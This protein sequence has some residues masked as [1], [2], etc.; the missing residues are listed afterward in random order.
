MR[1]SSPETAIKVPM[2]LATSATNSP[3]SSSV[4]TPRVMST[5]YGAQASPMRRTCGRGAR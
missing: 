5:G 4:W 1:V 2:M 3:D